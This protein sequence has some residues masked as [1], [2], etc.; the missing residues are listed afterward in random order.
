MN[1]RLAFV[2]VALLW[3]LVTAAVQLKSQPKLL[4]DGGCEW[5]TDCWV[6]SW[7]SGMVCWYCDNG[8][9]GCRC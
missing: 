5:M 4:A 1:K 2:R 7:S 3:M 6:C 9:Q 8:D